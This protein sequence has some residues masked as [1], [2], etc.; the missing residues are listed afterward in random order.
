MNQ[1]TLDRLRYAPEVKR[2]HVNDIFKQPIDQSYPGISED[3]LIR[4]RQ[5][6]IKFRG[7]MPCPVD[8]LIPSQPNIYADK[9][10]W[11]TAHMNEMPPP[12]IMFYNNR[13]FVIDG[14]HRIAA[15]ILKG[16]TEIQAYVVN[17]HW[18]TISF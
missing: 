1:Q 6:E 4:F 16:A 14:H 9:V 17:V 7:T 11:M 15:Q 18:T 12:L 3:L 13:L 5:G 8:K 10:D 2:V